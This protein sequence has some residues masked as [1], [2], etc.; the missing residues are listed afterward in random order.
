MCFTNLSFFPRRG[1]PH[2]SIELTKKK[3]G[4]ERRIFHSTNLANFMLGCGSPLHM[5]HRIQYQRVEAKWRVGVRCA[6]VCVSVKG[7]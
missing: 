5:V 7:D 2:C 4:K 1:K 3:W 6:V